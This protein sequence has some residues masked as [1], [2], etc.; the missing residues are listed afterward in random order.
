MSDPAAP[1]PSA[2]EA[3]AEIYVPG[4]RWAK[5]GVVL[6]GLLLITLAIYL[7]RTQL[8][9]LLAGTWVTAEIVHVVLVEPS[10]G[11]RVFT[12]EADLLA[13]EKTTEHDQHAVYMPEFTFRGPDGATVTVR[14]SHGSRFRSPDRLADAD[15]LP[16]RVRAC[17]DPLDPRI[18]VL[19]FDIRI[20]FAS[21]MIALVAGLILF[22]GGMLWWHAERPIE[23]PRRS[24]GDGAVGPPASPPAGH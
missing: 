12:D 18:A 19:P 17:Y 22:I 10:G 14:S 1:L 20:W 7:S 5:L 8:R 3:P 4:L 9:L 6:F 11:A 16:V 13:H 2:P 24:A 21:G 15:G 23:M